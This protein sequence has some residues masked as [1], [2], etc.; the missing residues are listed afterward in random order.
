[1]P[2]PT[3]APSRRSERDVLAHLSSLGPERRLA[4]YHAGRFSHHQLT[5]WAQAFPEEVPLVNGELPWIALG[6]ADID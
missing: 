3:I 2:S 1:M 4:E 5:L 6:L